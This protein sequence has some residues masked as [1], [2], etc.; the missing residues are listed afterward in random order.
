MVVSMPLLCTTS[1]IGITMM[2][3]TRHFHHT[4]T[5]VVTLE[6]RKLLIPLGMVVTIAIINAQWDG[7]ILI[8]CVSFE[9][10]CICV[11]SV[12]S[13]PSKTFPERPLKQTAQTESEIADEQLNVISDPAGNPV[14]S[15]RT[16]MK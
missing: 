6:Q 3:H 16:W 13:G 5:R 15:C 7:T 4:H 11:Q 2:A 1:D 10:E 8:Q 9:T 14:K 12:T